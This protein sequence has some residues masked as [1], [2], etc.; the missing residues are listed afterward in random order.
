MRS[1]ETLLMIDVYRA[2]D[3]GAV[4]LQTVWSTDIRSG[5]RR[6]RIET[7]VDEA[8]LQRRLAELAAEI[9]EPIGLAAAA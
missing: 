4:T 5:H 1:G 6:T 2:R 9:F 7:V 3:G 8:S